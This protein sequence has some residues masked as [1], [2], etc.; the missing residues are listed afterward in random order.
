[1]NSVNS[2]TY[3]VFLSHTWADQRNGQL[4]SQPL[5]DAWWCAGTEGVAR[6]LGG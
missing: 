3:D 5:A 1:M 2:P 4:L 6:P